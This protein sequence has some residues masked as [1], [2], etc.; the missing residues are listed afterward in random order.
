MAKKQL[1]R[2]VGLSDLECPFH[3]VTITQCGRIG[4]EAR[5]IHVSTTFAGQK[6]GVTQLAAACGWS[7][8]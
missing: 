1:W 3:D 5:K 8:F 6:A 4:I 2:L 7:A